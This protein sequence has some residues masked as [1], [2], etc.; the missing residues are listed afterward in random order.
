MRLPS[1]PIITLTTDFGV[2]DHY[3]SALKGVI[4]GINPRATIVDVSHEI[5][6]QAIEE[7]AFLLSCALPYFPRGSIHVVV[8]DPRVGTE[9]KGLALVTEDGVFV[10]PDNGVLS[11]ALND[12]ERGGGFAGTSRIAIPAGKAGFL[13]VN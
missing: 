13:L 1:S 12:E 10:G 4:L 9:R 3:V 7:G 6:P 2:T 11:A 5:K 8:V